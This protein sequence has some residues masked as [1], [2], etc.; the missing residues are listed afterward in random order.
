ML[1]VN[2]ANVDLNV[3]LYENALCSKLYGCK[4]KTVQILIDIDDVS[5]CT[6]CDD[7]I[8]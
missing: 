2:S 5:T 3:L 1:N 6:E 8:G 4:L 7:Q